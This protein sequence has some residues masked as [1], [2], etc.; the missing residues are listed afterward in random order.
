MKSNNKKSKKFAYIFY[1]TL[2]LLIAFYGLLSIELLSINFNSNIILIIAGV[3]SFY[4]LT[5]GF[6]FYTLDTAGETLT[7]ITKRYDL[8]SFLDTTEK[9]VDL[10]KYKLNS[11]EFNPGL[12][13]DDLT[14]LINSRKNKSNIIKVKLKISFLSKEEREKI[15]DE[16]NKIVESNQYQL[17]S[18]VA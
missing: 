1:G 7:L 3:L 5:R 13:N 14:L 9:K 17:E 2:F 8:F 11:F 15:I 4:I 16:L 6:Q 10:P 18:K 12:I